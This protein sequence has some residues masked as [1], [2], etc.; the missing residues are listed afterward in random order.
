[1]VSG[2]GVIL[3]SADVLLRTKTQIQIK[4]GRTPHPG[5]VETLTELRTD[6]E[7][8]H[9]SVRELGTQWLSC[10]TELMHHFD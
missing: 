3:G 2:S 7:E 4:E 5:Y 1:M 8:P 10:K 9:Y 6:T